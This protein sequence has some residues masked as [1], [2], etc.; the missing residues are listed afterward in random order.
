MEP[1]SLERDH[2]HFSSP[3][4]F[5]LHDGFFLDCFFLFVTKA[6]MFIVQSIDITTSDPIRDICLFFFPPIG[7]PT[8]LYG[9]GSWFLVSVTET[10]HTC[11]G[12]VTVYFLNK[13]DKG[14]M[15]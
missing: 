3:D 12:P 2:L 11:H 7:I 6:S 8:L 15:Y 9:I 14:A 13:E 10:V 4:H 5:N 1:L